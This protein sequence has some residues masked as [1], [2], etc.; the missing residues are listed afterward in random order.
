MK[1]EGLF[2][3]VTLIQN[4]IFYN[5]ADYVLR[6]RVLD[7]ANINVQAGISIVSFVL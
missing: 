1:S 7:L 3:S 4:V 2:Y 5:N 6:R